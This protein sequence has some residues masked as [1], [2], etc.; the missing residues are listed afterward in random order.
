MMADLD[1]GKTTLVCSWFFT[2]LA[3][4]SIVIQ[5]LHIRHVRHSDLGDYLVLISFAIAVIL[6]IQTT[7]AVLDKGQGVHESELVSSDF[8]TVAKS[9][10][11]N[12]LLWGL[13]NTLV[14]VSALLLYRK[15][16][17]VHKTIRLLTI[18]VIFVSGAFGVVIIL[19]SFLVCRP[20]SAAWDPSSS[21]NEIPSYVALEACG[22]VLDIIIVILPI[23]PIQHLQIQTKHKW[24]ISLALSAGGIVVIITALRLQA[25]HLVSS[26]DLTHDKGY[27]SLL[28]N[29]GALLA[30]T[31]CS[32]PAISAYFV[33]RQG[34]FIRRTAAQINSIY[35]EATSR[36]TFRSRVEEAPK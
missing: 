12:E 13:V 25:L 6:V 16:F 22:L 30:I 5:A 26:T 14:R 2:V 36:L 34:G 23:T 15:L 21:C 1:I 32:A 24:Q 17:G 3:T 19:T 9:V 20:V 8:A 31:C 11:A 33:R 4:A 18:I 28:S 35:I 27:L 10:F 29:L 7:W